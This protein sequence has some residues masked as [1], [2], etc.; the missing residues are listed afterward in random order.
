VRVAPRALCP[1]RNAP[2]AS[3]DAVAVTTY[4]TLATM[5]RRADP[6]RIYEAG[7]AAIQNRLLSAGMDDAPA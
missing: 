6:R 3:R 1:R 2:S 4:R 5:A 7:R